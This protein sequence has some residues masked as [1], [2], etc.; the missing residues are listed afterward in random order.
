M[1]T[2]Q[3]NWKTEPCTHNFSGEEEK[4]MKIG[5]VVDQMLLAKLAELEAAAKVTRLKLEGGK[6]WERELSQECC[7][8]ASIASECARLASQLRESR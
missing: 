7:R 1:L 8:L 5:G 2:M 4:K 3:W 6:H